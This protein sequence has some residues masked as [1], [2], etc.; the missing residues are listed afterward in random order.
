MSYHLVSSQDNPSPKVSV[1]VRRKSRA[2]LA[3]EDCADSIEEKKA[4]STAPAEGG[5]HMLSM[6]NSFD[7]ESSLDAMY[8]LR[9]DEVRNVLEVSVVCAGM[10]KLRKF[11]YVTKGW[12]ISRYLANLIPLLQYPTGCL[13][14]KDGTDMAS[15]NVAFTSS[16]FRRSH[17]PAPLHCLDRFTGRIEANIQVE[18]M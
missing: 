1:P 12:R 11:K 4:E 7:D 3:V 17:C 13:E 14:S 16:T 18:S 2:S 9:E 6:N 10:S 8:R 5:V 15:Y